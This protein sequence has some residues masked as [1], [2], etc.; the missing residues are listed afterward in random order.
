MPT[1]QWDQ[2]S[3]AVGSARGRRR[4]RWIF[5]GSFTDDVVTPADEETP[6]GDNDSEEGTVYNILNSVKDL[7]FAERK[8]IMQLAA[9]SDEEDLKLFA[10]Y[11]FSFRSDK[12]ILC[13]PTLK[14]FNFMLPRSRLGLYLTFEANTT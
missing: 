13:L 1:A 6:L 11:G 8:S 12:N 10:R 3:D 9:A 7:S 14:I 2:Q 5:G 4:I